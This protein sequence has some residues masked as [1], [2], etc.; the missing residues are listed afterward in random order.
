MSERISAKRSKTPIVAAVLAVLAS[1]TIGVSQYLDLFMSAGDMSKQESEISKVLEEIN[2]EAVGKKEEIVIDCGLSAIEE[3]VV[4]DESAGY[5]LFIPGKSS[6]VMHLRDKFCKDFLRKDPDTVA[7]SLFA[8]NYAIY[9][10]GANDPC[11][12]KLADEQYPYTL[13]AVYG[14]DRKAGEDFTRI[15]AGYVSREEECPKTIEEI[16]S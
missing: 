4:S 15:L 14:G 7:R 5:A 13:E 12:M 1:T 2:L 9:R 6:N 16:I 3:R 8:F 10:Y 11:N